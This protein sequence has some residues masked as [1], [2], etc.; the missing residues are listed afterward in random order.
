MV[1]ITGRTKSGIIGPK[2]SSDDRWALVEYLK[3]I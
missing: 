3:S 2:L 1:Y